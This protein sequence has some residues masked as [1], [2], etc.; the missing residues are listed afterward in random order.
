MQN[1]YF[2]QNFSQK[3]FKLFFYIILVNGSYKRN[4]KI[5]QLHVKAQSFLA[6]ITATQ[7][8]C[9]AP[10]PAPREPPQSKQSPGTSSANKREEAYQRSIRQWMI[11]LFG[12]ISFSKTLYFQKARSCLIAKFKIPKLSHRKR[13]LHSWS[14]KSKRNKK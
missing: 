12:K 3:S 1:F 9:W 6:C 10:G 11:F 2:S 7:N 14:I 5:W 4:T 13:I 8:L